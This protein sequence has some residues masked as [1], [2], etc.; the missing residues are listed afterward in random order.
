VG[1]VVVSLPRG[2]GR[3]HDQLNKESVSVY[4]ACEVLLDDHKRRRRG[5]EVPDA[6]QAPSMK[7]RAA[8]LAASN[9]VT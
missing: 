5:R 2:G 1:G 4:S 7:L 9:C 6:L 8:G 3:T